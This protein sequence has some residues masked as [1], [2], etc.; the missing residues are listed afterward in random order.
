MLR[1]HW[2]PAGFAEGGIVAFRQRWANY[3]DPYYNVNL[4]P[5]GSF[6]P[7]LDS[8]PDLRVRER[9]W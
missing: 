7:D 6:Q 5:D 4:S 2:S 1:T 3:R 9:P 8:G